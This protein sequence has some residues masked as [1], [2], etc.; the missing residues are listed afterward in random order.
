VNGYPVIEFD[1]FAA[2]S[3]ADLAETPAT[4]IT[5]RLAGFGCAVT[6]RLALAGDSCGE[7]V[8][9]LKIAAAGGVIFGFSLPALSQ[10]RELTRILV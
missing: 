4:G 3:V 5:F 8:G 9:I 7:T 6:L 10:V 1:Y 2:T